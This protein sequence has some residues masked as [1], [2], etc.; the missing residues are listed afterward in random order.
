MLFRSLDAVTRAVQAE[1][2]RH[3]GTFHRV[4]VDDK[5]TNM[6]CVWG[7]PGCSH[8][9]DAV[10][11]LAT[12]LALPEILHAHGCTGGIGIAS[13]RAL[14]GPAGGG[15]RFE[16]TVVGDTVNLAARLTGAGTPGMV[17]MT[18]TVRAQLGDR[19]EAV[20]GGQRHLKGKGD[21][22]VFEVASVR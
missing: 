20:D 17:C 6:L 13:G 4:I 9:D 21:V 14:C 11:A 22:H 19:V 7:V 15:R 1:V 12:A 16:Y 18:A 10:R 5:G 3:E 2:A 8:E